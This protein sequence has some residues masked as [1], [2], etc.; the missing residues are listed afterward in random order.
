[1]Q[2]LQRLHKSTM[3]AFFVWY[4]NARTNKYFNSH[5]DVTT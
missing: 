2:F 4:S 1:M 5:V 3:S